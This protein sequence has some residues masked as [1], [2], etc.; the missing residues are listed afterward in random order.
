MISLSFLFGFVC[1]KSVLA[2]NY[3]SL[4]QIVL[5]QSFDVNSLCSQQLSYFQTN[6]NHNVLWARKLRDSWGNLPS[7]VF[8]GNL[9]DFGN[10]DQCIGFKYKSSKV[11]DILGQH[12]TLLTPFDQGDDSNQKTSKFMVPTRDSQINLGIG[13]CFPASC[14]PNQVKEIANELLKVEFN[15][16]AAPDYD[17][18]ALCSTA[19][20]HL[21]FNGLQIFAT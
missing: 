21:E 5:P 12:C 9:Y 4:N 14:H 8:S 17:Q 16:T 3:K 2:V 15:V 19:Q 18:S 10:F 11:G 20:E 6:L 1:L 13:I 7:G